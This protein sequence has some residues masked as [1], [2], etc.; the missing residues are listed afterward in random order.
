MLRLYA[1]ATSLYASGKVLDHQAHVRRPVGVQVLL[2]EPRRHGGELGRGG[3]VGRDCSKRADRDAAITEGRWRP[4][5][6]YLRLVVFDR[7]SGVVYE[8]ENGL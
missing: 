3:R 1:T 4:C 2:V 6:G 8:F 7:L 5:T